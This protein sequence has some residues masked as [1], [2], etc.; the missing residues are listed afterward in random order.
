MLPDWMPAN[1]VP[2]V[3][4]IGDTAWRCR[5]CGDS[6]TQP[7]FTDVATFARW[8]GWIKRK[9]A[10]CGTFDDIEPEA[11][12]HPLNPDRQER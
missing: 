5:R 2:W 4:W 3:E 10:G 8:L 11:I 9:H 12:G 6:G 7:P 1:G